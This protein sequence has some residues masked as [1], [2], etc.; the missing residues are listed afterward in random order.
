MGCDALR[1]RETS[2]GTSPQSRRGVATLATIAFSSSLFI[3]HRH[4]AGGPKAHSMIGLRLKILGFQ[5]FECL[6]ILG[7]HT[8]FFLGG[9]F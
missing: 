3:R 1:V 8:F 5:D 7:F 4:I 9:S 2:H 6:K